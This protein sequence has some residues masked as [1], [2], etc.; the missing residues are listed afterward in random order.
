MHE[1]RLGGSIKRHAS[2][3][4]YIGCL[5]LPLQPQFKSKDKNITNGNVQWSAYSANLY[6]Q[7]QNELKSEGWWV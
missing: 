4:M 7:W 1:L 2:F 5:R 6:L 3:K